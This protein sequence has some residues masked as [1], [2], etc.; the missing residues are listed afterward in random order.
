MNKKTAEAKADQPRTLEDLFT[1][2]KRFADYEVRLNT[3]SGGMGRVYR[4]IQ[5]FDRTSTYARALKDFGR[6]PIVQPTSE[7]QDAP[8]GPLEVAVTFPDSW[9]TDKKRLSRFLRIQK[10]AP[11]MPVRDAYDIKPESINRQFERLLG[12]QG[13]VPELWYYDLAP[14]SALTIDD[15]QLYRDLQIMRGVIPPASEDEKLEAIRR[16]VRRIPSKL[17]KGEANDALAR[18]IMTGDP[19]TKAEV[20]TMLL[21]MLAYEVLAMEQMPAR[22]RIGRS[23]I[24]SVSD[25]VAEIVPRTLTIRDYWLWFKTRLQSALEEYVLGLGFKE[26]GTVS[27]KT[28]ELRGTMQ[29]EAEIE[30]WERGPK[31]GNGPVELVRFGDAEK[32][33]SRLGRFQAIDEAS[34]DEANF[35]VSL[36]GEFGSFDSIEASDSDYQPLDLA[37]CDIANTI[38]ETAPVIESLGVEAGVNPADIVRGVCSGMAK[39]DRQYLRALSAIMSDT[40]GMSMD[41]AHLAVQKKLGITDKNRR[42]IWFRIKRSAKIAQHT[43]DLER[44]ALGGHPILRPDGTEIRLPAWAIGMLR[45]LQLVLDEPGKPPQSNAGAYLVAGSVHLLAKEL[46]RRELETIGILSKAPIGDEAAAI[47]TR[48]GVAHHG[49]VPTRNDEVRQVVGKSADLPAACYHG[50]GQAAMGRLARVL[51]PD[52]SGPGER[53]S[54]NCPKCRLCS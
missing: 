36:D 24:K 10:S 7:W 43:T 31:P 21:P 4:D 29:G 44:D 52:L 53:L 8:G 33:M 9:E 23:H 20:R 42:Q 37:D 2:I 28:P 12:D 6:N 34:P 14:I 40:P 27:P 51:G 49:A 17:R 46:V 39:R 3:A 47:V 38:D 19:Y 13:V 54:C 16:V 5:R 25:K 48:K 15:L 18:M 41:D 1:S 26:A 22:R 35:E 50:Y 11:V 30:A 45:H 32:V